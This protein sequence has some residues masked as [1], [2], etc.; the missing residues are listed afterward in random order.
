[1]FVCKRGQGSEFLDRKVRRT[2]RNGIEMTRNVSC[3]EKI[4]VSDG[5]PV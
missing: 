1:M 2:V 3:T 4:L 5:G